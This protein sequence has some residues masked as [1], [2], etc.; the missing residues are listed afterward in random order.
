MK[1]IKSEGYVTPKDYVHYLRFN[2]LKGKYY[3]L[4][5]VAFFVSVAVAVVWLLLAGLQTGN[6]NMWI[7]AGVILLCIGMFFYTVNNN[8]KR[9]CNKSAKVVRATQCT[10]FGKN[11]FVFELRFQ[12]PSE[13]EFNEILYDEV[14]MIYLAPHAMYIYIEKRSVVIIPKRNLQ[15]TPNEALEF[16]E[17][18]VDAQKVCVCA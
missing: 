15:I 5:C 13:N 9:L 18:F 17:K 8:V 14:E 10:E 1:S 4:K 6:K 16:L 11:G 7:I 12:D 3:R 2:M